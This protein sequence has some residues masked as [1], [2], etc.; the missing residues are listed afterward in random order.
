[1]FNMNLFWPR[2]FERAFAPL[3]AV[4]QNLT[5]IP[6]FENAITRQFLE[7]FFDF[8]VLIERTISLDYTD[9]IFVDLFY[10]KLKK[11]QHI[12]KLF[13]GLLH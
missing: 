12:L 3:G 2:H 5:E 11:L 6:H 13:S 9:V 10:L 8:L 7:S 4:P 1:M